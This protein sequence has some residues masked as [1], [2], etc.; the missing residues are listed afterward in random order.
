MVFW[1]GS[2]EKWRNCIWWRGGKFQGECIRL[3][4]VFQRAPAIQTA[5]RPVHCRGKYIITFRKMQLGNWWGQ[6]LLVGR[7]VK[8]GMRR[9]TL[10]AVG[11]KAYFEWPLRSPLPVLAEDLVLR[12]ESSLYMTSAYGSNLLLHLGKLS[13]S[14]D[15]GKPTF[16]NC[17]SQIIPHLAC[18]FLMTQRWCWGH[19]LAEQGSDET[20]LC[21]RKSTIPLCGN[22]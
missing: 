14:W 18:L 16:L 2:Q 5:F 10:W 4:A 1:A 3:L 17:T 21:F 13:W 11:E 12:T 8:N 6:K 7:S 9:P 15:H 20:W 19:D 22:S